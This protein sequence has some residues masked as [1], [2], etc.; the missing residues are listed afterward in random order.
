MVLQGQGRTL[1]GKIGRLLAESLNGEQILE[2]QKG[3]LEG[4]VPP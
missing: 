3:R 1:L 2:E 4:D